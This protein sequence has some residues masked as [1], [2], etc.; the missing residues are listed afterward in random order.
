MTRMFIATCV[1]A[2]EIIITLLISGLKGCKSEQKRG[3]EVK[4]IVVMKLNTQVDTF[5]ALAY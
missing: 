2:R 4:F 3:C 5:K 1:P